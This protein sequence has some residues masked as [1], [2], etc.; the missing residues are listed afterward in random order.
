MALISNG[1]SL[2]IYFNGYMNFSLTKSA[3]TVTNFMGTAFLLS[4][5]GAFLSD[6]YFSRFKTC[7]LF[8]II[9]VLVL[10]YFYILVMQENKN[11]R[12][13]ICPCRIKNRLDNSFNL[14]DL[15]C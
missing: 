14:R 5:F 1:V 4:L 11:N 3:N 9:K 15:H 6:T 12:Y 13:F 8:G 7:V 10:V 2:V